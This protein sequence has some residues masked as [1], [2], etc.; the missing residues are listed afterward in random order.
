MSEVVR[1]AWVNLNEPL[2]IKYHDEEWGVPL[3]HND[4]A[5]FERLCLEGAQAGLS[6]LTI[7]RKRENYRA[8]FDGFDPALVARYD[9]TKIAAL[10]ANPGIVRN[11]L[12]INAA[13]HNAQRF[14][15]VQ[16]EFGSFDQYLWAFVEGRPLQNRWQALR[17]VPA[18]TDISRR[19]SKDL[20]A[21]GFKFVGATICYAM[22][23]AIGMVNDHTI[24]C[25]RCH[26]I[27]QL[28][29]QMS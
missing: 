3:R 11:R 2:Y 14:L 6:W 18:E 10:L 20:Q 9:E 29:A 1:C 23:Q 7:L 26:T 12:K 22:M 21:R 5:L 4:R 13:V 8:A 17:E 28:G 15:A 24:D 16:A 25:F 27:A 19:L